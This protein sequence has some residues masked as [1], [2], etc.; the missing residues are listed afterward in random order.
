MYTGIE[1]GQS[2]GG[3]AWK[4]FLLEQIKSAAFQG[5]VRLKLEL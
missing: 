3:S 5:L 4:K 1:S 2:G